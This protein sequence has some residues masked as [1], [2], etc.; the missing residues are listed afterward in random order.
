MKSLAC[1]FVWWPG[2]DQH[3][4]E[5]ANPVQSVNRVNHPLQLLHCVHGSGLY[6]H[7]HACTLIL[8]TITHFL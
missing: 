4:D 8:L 7:G 5:T 2:M 3:I 6:D 1:I